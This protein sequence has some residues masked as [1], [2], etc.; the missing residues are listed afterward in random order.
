ALLRHRRAQALAKAEPPLPHLARVGIVGGRPGR[1]AH[2]LLDLLQ[3][4]L[5]ARGGSHGL[6][7][8]HPHDRAL[9]LA[10]REV[11]IDEAGSHEHAADQHEQDDDVLAEESPAWSP[12][13][14]RRKASARSRIFRGTA[15]PKRSAV[16]RFTARSI[17]SAPSIGR[18]WGRAPRRILATSAAAWT[19]CA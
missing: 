10:V 11:E 8:P 1:L 2:L 12:N 14:H 17:R 15:R 19:P 6:G 13:P 7:A 18:S 4:L 9:G 5:D 16:L 3:E